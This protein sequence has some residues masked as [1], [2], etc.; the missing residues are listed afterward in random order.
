MGHAELTTTNGVIMAPED[1]NAR[2]KTL[3]YEYQD[4]VAHVEREVGIYQGYFANKC[5]I[6]DYD[7]RVILKYF[8]ISKIEFFN[9]KPYEILKVPQMKLYEKD[10][11]P[12]EWEVI[13]K[14]IKEVK[15]ERKRNKKM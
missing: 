13:S 9:M 2:L 5:I 15:N 10:Y 12:E 11:S 8:G 3:C 4:N 6:S 14:V 7:I 1:F